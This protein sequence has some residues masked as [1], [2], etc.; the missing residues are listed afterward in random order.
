MRNTLNFKLFFIVFDVVYLQLIRYYLIMFNHRLFIFIFVS[1]NLFTHPELDQQKYSLDNSYLP[2]PLPDRVVLTWNDDPA[3]TQAVNWR[4]DT[5]VTKALAQLAIAN[6]NGRALL[7]EE[8][9][10]ETSY[11]KSDINEAHY[12][13]VTFRNLK[14]DTLYAY[15]VGDGSYWSEYYHFKTASNEDKPFSFI[16]FGDAQNDVRTHWS[17]VFREAFRD[18]PRAA[19]TLHAGDLVDE[20]NF[21]SQWGDWHQGPDW[22]NGTIPVIATPGNHE[23]Q[24]QAEARRIWT[25]KEGNN[26]NIDIESLNNDILGILMLDI[27]DSKGRKG[28]I[29]INEKSG[30]IIEVD[31][32]IELI[33][34]FTNEELANQS[35]LGGKAPLYD[36]LRNPIRTYRVSN[37]WRHQ[38]S[39][40]IANVPDERLKETVYFIDYQG[41]RFI[42]LDSNIANEIQVDWLRKT[43]E[44]NPNRWTIITF[45][46]P[47]YSPASSRDNQKIR[48]LWKPLLDEFKVDLVLS[49]HDHTYSRT[50]LV[51][52][53]NVKNIPTGYQQAYDPNIGTVHVVSVSGPKMYEITKGKYAKKFG[54]NVQLYQII[55]VKKNRLRFRAY[56]ATGKLFDEFTLKKRKNQPNLLVEPNS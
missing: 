8:F 1:L 26:I 48:Q 45:H 15:R 4:T 41:V 30:K 35:I 39:F 31:E 29:E 17:R 36:R 40:P 44:N 3:S 27:K 42:S 11:L 55:D 47:L 7:T 37:H 10:A 19:F 2:S 56:T 22:V 49:G 9:K 16:Y 54:E 33:T 14:P 34:G 6:S 24:N 20:H 50:G 38:F 25:S 43:L 12:H 52:F 23:Y 13:S 21:D 5:T 46:H 28:S 18:A 32:G 51:D 53:K